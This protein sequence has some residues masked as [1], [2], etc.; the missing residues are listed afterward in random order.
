MR[1]DCPSAW[2]CLHVSACERVVACEIGSVGISICSGT[3]ICCDNSIVR[4]CGVLP[5]QMVC[6]DVGALPACRERQSKRGGIN[7]RV[8]RGGVVDMRGNSST[9][10][11]PKSGFSGLALGLGGMAVCEYECVRCDYT[12]VSACLNVASGLG[13]HGRSKVRPSAM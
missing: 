6:I 2:V 3:C 13:G 4:G 12:S 11:R 9:V 7:L 1:C 10:P 5:R 8:Q